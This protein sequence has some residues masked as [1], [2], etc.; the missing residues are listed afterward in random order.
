MTFASEEYEK[1]NE[2]KRWSAFMRAEGY[3]YNANSKNHIAK[4]HSNLKPYKRLE[5]FEKDKD[6]LL[7]K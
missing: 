3:V 2:H 7:K 6:L 5:G 1:E 4:T